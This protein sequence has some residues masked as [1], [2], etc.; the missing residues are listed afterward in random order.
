MSIHFE[1]LS[2]IDI[3]DIIEINTNERVLEQMP[4]AQDIVFDHQQC[5]AWVKAK[6]KHWD[7]Y[8]Y[9][10]WAFLLG[11]NFVGWGGLQF[12]NGDPDLALVLHPRYWGLGKKIFKQIVNIAFNEY[13]FNSITILLLP[14]RNKLKA[15]YLLGFKFDGEVTIDN[16]LFIRYR[17][18]KPN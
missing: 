1:R 15:I 11:D 3:K 9:G 6:E 12:E 8:G 14:S 16:Q 13:K 2:H 18:Y 17:L 10:I 7:E 4:L 5:I